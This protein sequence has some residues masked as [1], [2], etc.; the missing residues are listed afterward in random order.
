MKKVV[1]KFSKRSVSEIIEGSRAI[2]N[3]LTGNLNFPTPN[4]VLADITDMINDLELHYLAAQYG[5]LNEKALMRSAKKLLLQ[6]LALLQAYVQTTSNG[7]EALI[8]STGF[9]V[10]KDN[11]KVGELPPPAN[12]RAWVPKKGKKIRVS[13]L[14]VKG[15][16]SY[17][18]QYS[19]DPTKE[20]LWANAPKGIVTRAFFD[21]EGLIRGQV[22]WFRVFSVGAAGISGPSDPAEV[23]AP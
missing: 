7:G 19:V 11:S 17:S 14:G 22:F 23:V 1:L 21:I 8:L 13:W 9:G 16:K 12:V 18:V 10:R 3:K 20:E 15:R 4:P 5:D 6:N 2:V